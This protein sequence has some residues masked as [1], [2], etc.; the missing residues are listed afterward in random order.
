MIKVVCVKWGTEFSA[1]YVNKLYYGIKR[2]TTIPFKFYCFTEDST[3]IN[4]NV[5]ILPFSIDYL[6]GWWNKMYLFHPDNGLS[7]DVL[8][9]DLDVLITNNID[10]FL[11][12]RDNFTIMCKGIFDSN[13][14]ENNI[15]NSSMY[16]FNHDKMSYMWDIFVKNIE[17]MAKLKGDQCFLSKYLD[18]S[19]V[20]IFQ[21]L[22]P[23]RLK[24]YKWDCYENGFPAGTSMIHFHGNP[25]P[26]QAISET[27]TAGGKIYKPRSWVKDYWVETI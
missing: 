13:P 18:H 11:Q 12:P 7:G 23:D 22:F 25:R 21:K 26:H 14:K 20:D 17:D 6:K 15:F 16:L 1:E 2:N 5:K 3:S 19:K 8:F 4:S 24:S 10:D 9:L 27:I